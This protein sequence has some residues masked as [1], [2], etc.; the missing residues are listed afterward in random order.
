[1]SMTKI[2][3]LHAAGTTRKAR[4]PIV[5]RAAEHTIDFSKA[6]DETLVRIADLVRDQSLIPQVQKMARFLMDRHPAH[7]EPLIR[8]WLGLRDHYSNA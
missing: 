3:H 8:R 2:E 4:G 1:M 5:R 7:V 6:S